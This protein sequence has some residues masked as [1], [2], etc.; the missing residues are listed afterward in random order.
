M[1]KI[2]TFRLELQPSSGE[3]DKNLHRERTCNEGKLGKLVH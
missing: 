2:L 1:F 3:S